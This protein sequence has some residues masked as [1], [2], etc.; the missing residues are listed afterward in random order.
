M[1][2]LN[3]TPKGR[4]FTLNGKTLYAAYTICSGCEGNIYEPNKRECESCEADSKA[5]AAKRLELGL[6]K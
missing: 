4:P 5:W 1:T 6:D 2:S 3:T